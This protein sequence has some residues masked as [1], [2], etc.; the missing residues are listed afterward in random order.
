[1][2]FPRLVSWTDRPEEGIKYYSGKAV[3]S[4]T[5]NIANENPDFKTLFLDLGDVKDVGI[6]R[7]KLNGRDVGTVWTPPFR[8]SVAGVLR[9]GNNDLEIE[10]VN[11]WRN[12]LVGDRGKPQEQRLTKTNI[13]ILD[14][15]QLL[16][17]GLLGPVRL[18]RGDF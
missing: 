4:I 7:V 10:V 15:W 9:R 3:Y 13:K 5:F 11:T 17:S 12:R 1:M 14:T 18:L 2:A 16:P 8:V 6:A